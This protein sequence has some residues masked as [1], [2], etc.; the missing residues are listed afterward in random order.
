MEAQRAEHRLGRQQ[1]IAHRVEQDQ[2]G[3]VR[4]AAGHLG[5][6]L[7]FPAPPLPVRVSSRVVVSRR[8]T[9]RSSA[10]RPA[11]LVTSAGRLDR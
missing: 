6:G 4:E 8:L 1:G 10:R 11:K 7:V 5:R 3:A 2:A 9:S